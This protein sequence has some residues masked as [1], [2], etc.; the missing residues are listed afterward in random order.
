MER[1]TS[2][3]NGRSKTLHQ[4]QIDEP[5]TTPKRLPKLNTQINEQ[6]PTRD[7]Y[8]LGLKNQRIPSVADA[9]TPLF[10]KKRLHRSRRPFPEELQLDSSPA[11]DQRG[12]LPRDRGVPPLQQKRR[13]K[14]GGERLPAALAA[15]AAANYWQPALGVVPNGRFEEETGEVQMPPR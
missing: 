14:A 3:K 5:T 10:L 12:P 7:Q 15:R 9:C 6:S 1:I 8:S 13:E 4:T 2:P 11:R